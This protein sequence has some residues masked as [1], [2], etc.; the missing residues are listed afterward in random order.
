MRKIAYSFILLIALIA[1]ATT[2]RAQ[3][4]IDTMDVPLG[5][6]ENWNDYPA[7]SASMMFLSLPIDYGYKLPEGWDIPHYEI[8]ETINYSGFNIPIQASLPVGKIEND[9]V[10]M[11]Q[12]HGALVAE[13]F[14]MQD[15]MTPLAYSLA[16]SFL[17]SSITGTVLPSIIASGQIHLENILPLVDQIFEDMQNMDWM[18]QLIDSTD[19]NEFISGGFPLNGFEPKKLIGYYKYIASNVDSVRDNGAIVAFGTRYDTLLHRRMLVGAG[20][21]MLYQLYDTINYEPFTMDYFSLSEYFPA[22]YEFKEA[23]SMVVIVVSSA[24]EKARVRGSR[25]FIDSLRLVSKNIDCGHI[26]NFTVDEIGIITVKV[27]WNNTAAPDRWEVEYGRHGFTQGRGESFT[28]HDTSLYINNLEAGTEY[29]FYVRGLCGDTAYTD[30]V[31]ASATTDTIPTYGIGQIIDNQAQVYPNPAHGTITIQQNGTP[32]QHITLYSIDGRQ[33]L[34]QPAQGDHITIQLPHTG[35]F[36]LQLQ[37]P[38]GN[39]HRRITNR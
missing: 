15:M 2:S 28:T 32:I 35:L 38:E 5:C 22:G 33:I 11:P 36:I 6:F 39:I 17:D 3:I 29:D 26:T 14:V 9:T 10:N 25:I 13:S 12:G 24:N 8:N 37:T 20:S 19:I 7:D 31:F 27:S 1:S 16:S 4:A 18:L 23:D 21:K 30:W 34:S